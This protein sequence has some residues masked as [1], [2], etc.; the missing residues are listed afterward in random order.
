MGQSQS[1]KILVLELLE[2]S[3]YLSLYDLCILYNCSK[4]IPLNMIHYISENPNYIFDFFK[5]NENIMIRLLKFVLN[6][7]NP[8]INNLLNLNNYS[9]LHVATQKKYNKTIKLLV[10]SPYFDVNIAENSKSWT[11]LWIACRYGYVETLKTLLSID[12]IKKLG[13]DKKQIILDVNKHSSYDITP[14][15]IACSIG[16]IECVKIL[17]KIP[18]IDVNKADKEGITPLLAA[19]WCGHTKCVEALLN[20][21]SIDINKARND[22][23]TPLMAAI[24]NDRI[25]IIR[26]LQQIDMR[27]RSPTIC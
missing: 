6:K 15:Y 4:N 1:K 20:N 19:S 12:N 25:K 27:K 18:N 13:A 21:D 23:T 22:G 24:N 9:P 16:H 10:S 17:L 5:L 8:N 11:S 2:Y 3:G 14:L 7:Y 26:L